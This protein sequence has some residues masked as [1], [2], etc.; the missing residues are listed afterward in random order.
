MA[1]PT[2]FVNSY[3]AFASFGTAGAPSIVTTAPLFPDALSGL[4]LV[5]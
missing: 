5:I 4:V 2:G 3:F 1:V